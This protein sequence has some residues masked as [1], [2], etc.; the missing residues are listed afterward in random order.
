MKRKCWSVYVDL[1]N[2]FLQSFIVVE[3]QA[4]LS[5]LKS[6]ARC[7]T[8]LDSP[9]YGLFFSSV[10]RLLL[11]VYKSSWTL[12]SLRCNLRLLKSSE[13]FSSFLTDF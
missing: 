3:I 5:L 13:S 7:F 6:I 10:F 4:S 8:H 11:V 1:F 12:V 9:V 2:F